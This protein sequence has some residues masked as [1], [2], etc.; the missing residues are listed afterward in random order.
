[1][2]AAGLLCPP[3]ACRSARSDSPYVRLPALMHSQMVPWPTGQGSVPEPTR[4]HRVR[5]PLPHADFL[6][7]LLFSKV[8][9]FSL[10][11]DLLNIPQNILNYLFFYIFFPLSTSNSHKRQ[12]RISSFCLLPSQYCIRYVGRGL[13]GREEPL[14]IPSMSKTE[15][16]T[17]PPVAAT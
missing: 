6:P 7:L 5:F 15:G 2:S 3:Q 12:A 10:H 8:S 14:N 17:Q 4:E 1:M 16:S 9:F 13:L 11:F